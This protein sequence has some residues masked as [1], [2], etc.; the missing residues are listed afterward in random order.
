MYNTT[1]N[2]VNYI[3][4]VVV[5]G[6]SYRDMSTWYSCVPPTSS[7]WICYACML[8]NCLNTGLG[9]MPSQHRIPP[10]SSSGY[11]PYFP[12]GLYPL[13]PLRVCTP[14]FLFG[15]DNLIMRYVPYYPFGFYTPY[16]SFVFLQLPLIP[17]SHPTFPMYIYE[18]MHVV[19]TRGMAGVVGRLPVLCVAD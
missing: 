3:I 9:V 19:V 11:T 18:F 8:V 10:T 1:H 7:A 17:H 6:G 5:N 13:L 16:F 15:F 12:F 2:I 14:Y 4:Q